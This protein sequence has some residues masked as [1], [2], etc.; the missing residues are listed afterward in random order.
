MMKQSIRSISGIGIL[1]L[2]LSV[3]WIFPAP[4]QAS[5]VTELDFTSGSIA[6]MLGSTTVVSTPFTQNG[7]IVMGQYQPLPDIISPISLSV[8]VVGIYTFSL[9]TSGPDP[10]PTSSMSGTTI[11]ANLTSLSANLTGPGLSS[12]G[13]SLNIGGLAAGDFNTSTDAFSNLSWTHLLTGLGLPTGWSGKSLVFSLNGT[14][15]V[16]PAPVPLP[17]AALLF[18]SGL[19]GL[20]GV[21]RRKLSLT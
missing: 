21:L 9:F 13:I 14:A 12:G 1:L 10:V 3:L 20:A 7:E 8:P 6:L 19:L 4:A 16:G 17:A 15:Q 5:V 11:T 2:L 18:G